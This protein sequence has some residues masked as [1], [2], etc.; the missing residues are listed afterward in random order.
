MTGTI[1][2]TEE[3][4]KTSSKVSYSY[5]RHQGTSRHHSL[6]ELILLV[7]ALDLAA[8]R[9]RNRSVN[10]MTLRGNEGRD[11]V[12]TEMTI[13]ARHSSFSLCD[14]TSD[15]PID[16]AKSIFPPSPFFHLEEWKFPDSLSM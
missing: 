12:H 16:S 3:G 11:V 13:L 2:H 8:W 9:T 7:F 5:G 10:A 6:N 4:S 15:M 14:E 1:L